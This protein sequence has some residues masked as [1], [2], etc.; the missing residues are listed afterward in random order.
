MASSL[1]QKPLWLRVCSFLLGIIL[2]LTALAFIY[3]G[4]K[5]VTLGGSWYFLISGVLMLISGYLFLR[6]RSAGAVLYIVTMI[7]TIVWA[8]ADAGLN[9]WP[10]I[11]V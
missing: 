5:L 1:K 10:L 2:V 4:V 3:G 8:L 11:Y 7:G 9:F 6:S